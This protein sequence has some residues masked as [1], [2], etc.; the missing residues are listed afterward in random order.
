MN[1]KRC[2]V[3]ASGR[4]QAFP[5]PALSAPPAPSATAPAASSGGGVFESILADFNK[6]L[7][8][9]QSLGGASKAATLQER[10]PVSSGCALAADM[11]GNGQNGRGLQQVPSSEK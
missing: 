8:D 4:Q 7:G 1:L 2:Q 5:G 11:G 6:R 9:R 3:E 10:A